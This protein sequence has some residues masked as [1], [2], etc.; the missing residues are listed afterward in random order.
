M[1]SWLSAKWASSAKLCL[2]NC[3]AEI[4]D[5]L[6]PEVMMRVAGVGCDGCLLLI[7]REIHEG[8]RDFA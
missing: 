4:I 3:V 2:A 6:V 5:E 1:L 8:Q 7:R